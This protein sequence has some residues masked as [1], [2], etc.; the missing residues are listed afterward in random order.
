MSSARLYRIASVV[1]V[2]FAAGH[3]FGFRKVDP[4]WNA[5]GTVMAMKTPFEVQ[6]VMRGYWD[7]FSGFGFFATGLL[8][9]CAVLAWE[10]GGL[11]ADMMKRLT[12][13]RWAF[14]LCFVGLTAVAWFFIFPLP[15]IFTGL[16]ALI[17]VLAA[18]PSE[19]AKA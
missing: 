4:R 3:S 10:L 6:G 9:F 14:A 5:D 15:V 19:S 17:L 8:L 18:W 12:T 2:F 7:F 16:V 13:T 11:P 1:L